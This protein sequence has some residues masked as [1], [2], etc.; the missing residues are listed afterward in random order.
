[1]PNLADLSTA[2]K[3]LLGASVLMF[4]D[5]ILAW[6][7]LDLPDPVPDVTR[8]GWAGWGTLVGLL[9]VALIVWEAL[10][11]TDLL[12]RQNLTLPVAAGLISA[13]LAAGILLF[14]IIKFIADN[15]A[16]A[17]PAWVGLLLA[18]AIAIGGWLKYQETKEAAPAYGRPG[19]RDTTPGSYEGGSTS[20]PGGGTT[21]APGGT[22]TPGGPT[23]TP[24]GPTTP[25]GG[26]PTRDPGGPPPPPP[27]A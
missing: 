15:E 3:L 14:T 21:T 8:S 1:M 25:P 4:I 26:P 11:L 7:K 24:G 22:T 9:T 12:R 19:D 27:P 16:R 10:Q 20:T 2:T 23:T 6:Q 17:W 5:L 13:A 18:I